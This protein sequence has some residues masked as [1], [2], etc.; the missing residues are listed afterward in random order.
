MDVLTEPEFALAFLTGR[1]AYLECLFKIVEIEKKV[2][3]GDREREMEVY[4]RYL[5]KY[6]DPWREGVY[7]V[8]T[9][10]TTIFLDRAPSMSPESS[11]NCAC[12]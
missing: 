10:Y 6:V 4:A 3:E 8:I 1:G 11:H 5:K 2:I 9:Q 7:D 12:Y